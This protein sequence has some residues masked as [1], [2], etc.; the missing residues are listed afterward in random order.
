MLLVTVTPLLRLP[1]K[2]HREGTWR[3]AWCTSGLE[4]HGASGTSRGLGRIPREKEKD[5]ESHAS[6]SSIFKSVAVAEQAR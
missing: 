2:R 6:R 1:G 5:G 4:L 3:K